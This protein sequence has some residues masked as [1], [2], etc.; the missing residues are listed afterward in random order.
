LTDVC[1]LQNAPILVRYWSEFD[2]LY[3]DMDAMGC[4]TIPSL[5][6]DDWSAVANEIHPGLNETI[7]DLVFVPLLR[8]V[9]C[10]VLL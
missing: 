8:R 4:S 2:R 10:V 7:N 6:T 3:G 9:A 1:A 5:G